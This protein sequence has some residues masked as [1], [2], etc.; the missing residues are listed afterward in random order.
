MSSKTEPFF[1]QKLYMLAFGTF[2]RRQ[3]VW[4]RIYEEKKTSLCNICM[5]FRGRNFTFVHDNLVILQCVLH[6]T[7]IS[8][9]SWQFT[10][11]YTSENHMCLYMNFFTC[12]WGLVWNKYRQGR[13]M[14]SE[15]L[16]SIQKPN[17]VQC[18]SQK[19]PHTACKRSS[20]L[21][22][23][24]QHTKTDT[25]VT[26]GPKQSHVQWCGLCNWI[27]AYVCLNV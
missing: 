7:I 2:L 8:S 18:C 22:S 9:V 13:Y 5:N 3:K 14:G 27:P 16:T 20:V 17:E 15:C 21:Y 6:L 24:Q 25:M 10:A 19:L 26:G 12:K 23:R 1:V 4:D 11:N